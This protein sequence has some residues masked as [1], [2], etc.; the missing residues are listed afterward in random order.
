M[1]ELD[2]L[3]VDRA[4]EDDRWS[5]LA[6]SPLAR[7]LAAHGDLGLEDVSLTTGKFEARGDV[8]SLGP[9][10]TEI[11]RVSDDKALV[12]CPY[13]RVGATRE[14]LAASGAFVVDLTGAL[15]GLRIDRPDAETLVRRLTDLPLDA[16]PTVGALAHVQAWILRDGPTAFRIFFA[17]EYGDYVGE[18]VVDAAEGL[19]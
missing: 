10:G 13:E 5:P 12:L 4:V 6:R 18:V 16:L 14:A 2:F 15:A 1:I 9:D 3:S 11:I 17:Q 8:G 19:A 7:V